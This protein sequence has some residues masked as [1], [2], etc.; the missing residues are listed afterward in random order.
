MFKTVPFDEG[1][2]REMNDLQVFENSEFGRLEVYEINGKPYFPAAKCAGILG[3]SNPLKAIRDHCKGVVGHKALTKGG[4]QTI[5]VIAG[6]DLHQLIA[7]SRMPFAKELA[8]KLGMKCLCSTKEQDCLSVIIAAFSHLK[9]I[10][11]YQVGRFRIDLYFPEQRLAVECDE[12]NHNCSQ[13]AS[14]DARQKF[15][16]SVLGCRFVRFNPDEPGFNIGSVINQIML[17]V[18]A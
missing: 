17:E 18:V 9:S 12:N 6:D 4:P 7:R 14:D 5:K 15:I 2:G 8:D 10:S 1:N 16:E 13:Y 11:Q 3:Y